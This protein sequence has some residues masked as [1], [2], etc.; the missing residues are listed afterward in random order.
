MLPREV[1]FTLPER[2][3]RL[4]N[5]GWGTQKTIVVDSSVQDSGNSLGSYILRPGFILGKDNTTGRYFDPANATPDSAASTTGT[6]FTTSGGTTLQISINGGPTVTITNTTGTGTLSD[7][8]TDINADPI[9]GSHLIAS[10]S[11]TNL[12]L[13]M[14]QAGAH[15][16]FEIVGGTALSN[17]GLT[18]GVYSGS[19]ADYVVLD[20]Y[21]ILQDSTGAAINQ[22][23]QG[24]VEGHF[25]ESQL[26]GLTGEIK[27]NLLRRGASFA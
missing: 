17:L 11:G 19:D 16:F 10:A 1:S 5:K 22:E 6:S 23:A 24:W 12:K 3:V 26:I 15:N 8:I 7:W 20:E 2:L 14:A 9:V 18:A 4:N 25:D 21:V 27:A 13:E